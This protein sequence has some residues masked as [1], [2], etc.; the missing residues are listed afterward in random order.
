[1]RI[2]AKELISEVLKPSSRVH[3]QER[4]HIK[5]V[6]ILTIVNTVELEDEL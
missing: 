2:E 1:M 3:S 4:C 6:D 5:D